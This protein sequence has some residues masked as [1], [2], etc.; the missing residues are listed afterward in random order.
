VRRQ[1]RCCGKVAYASYDSAWHALLTIRDNNDPTTRLP[2]S[3][4]ECK[5]GAYH[6]T[7]WGIGR[8]P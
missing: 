2:T 4:Y 3:V 8:R 1:A 5:N 7:S 6:L